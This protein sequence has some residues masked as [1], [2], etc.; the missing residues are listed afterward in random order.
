MPRVLTRMV[1]LTG[2]GIFM[3]LSG[4]KQL[5][6]IRITISF[7]DLIPRSLRT[8]Q[9]FRIILNGLLFI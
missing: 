3:I 8:F 9:N 1:N 5:N 6:R 2:A 7:K 4:L